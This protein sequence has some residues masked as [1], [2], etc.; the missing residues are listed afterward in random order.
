MKRFALALALLCVTAVAY[1][2]DKLSYDVSDV[3]LIKAASAEILSSDDGV[4]VLVEDLEPDAVSGVLLT[5]KDEPVDYIEAYDIVV[6]QG[7]K[8]AVLPPTTPDAL[9]SKPGSYLITGQ[10]GEKKFIA[11]RAGKSSTWFEIEIKGRT[12]PDPEDPPAPGEGPTQDDLKAITQIASSAAQSL[13]D[14]PT[15]KSIASSLSSIV[16]DLD[17]DFDKAIAQYRSA[18]ASGLLNSPARPPYKDWRQVFRVPIDAKLSGLAEASRLSTSAHL[19]SIIK[20][21]IDGLSSMAQTSM[22]SVITVYTAESCAPCKQWMLDN[23]T[24]LESAGWTIKVV[25]AVDMRIP[26]PT[27]EVKYKGKKYPSQ[28]IG[29]MSMTQLSQIIKQVS[30]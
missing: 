10:P 6:V 28:I 21:I 15:A 3:T 9:Q 29:Y 19:Q 27:F 20:A 22:D 2:Q 5:I 8:L 12:T 23:R 7:R 25:D 13:D 18:I 11:V 17:S 4:L 16:N 1:A 24:K 14:Q 30:E 26:T